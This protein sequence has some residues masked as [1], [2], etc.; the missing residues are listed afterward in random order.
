MTRDHATARA[1]RS[2]LRVCAV[3]LIF[4]LVSAA[5]G[6]TEPSPSPDR[7]AWEGSAGA[8]VSSGIITHER[9]EL[10]QRLA[11]PAC[12]EAAGAAYRFTDVT[13]FPGAGETP[14]GLTNTF[15]RLDR[16]RLW[17]RTGQ[18]VDQPVLYVTVRG[19]TGIVAAYERLAPGTPCAG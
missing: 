15:T 9:R 1:V 10:A 11:L 4:A 12:I 18:V 6:P 19:S 2:G 17:S 16:W 7:R 5:C 14:P 13:P 3:L 8:V